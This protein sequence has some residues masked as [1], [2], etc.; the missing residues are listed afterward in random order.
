MGV[1]VGGAQGLLYD[2]DRAPAE[3]KHLLWFDHSLLLRMRPAPRTRLSTLDCSLA[4]CRVFTALTRSPAHPHPCR[5]RMAVGCPL[6]PQSTCGR[7]GA[8]PEAPLA[9]GI[10]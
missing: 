2:T 8:D 3:S 7:T 4:M 9:G 5:S 6:T 10:A 1:T